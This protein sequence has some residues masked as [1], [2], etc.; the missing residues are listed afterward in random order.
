MSNEWT[1]SVVSEYPEE[2][3]V[4]RSMLSILQGNCAD[5][6]R[7]VEVDSVDSAD[8]VLMS[9]RGADGASSQLGN[10]QVLAQLLSPGEAPNGGGLALQR[11]VRAMPFLDFLNTASEQLRS[12]RN[13]QPQASGPY[14][15][16]PLVAVCHALADLRKTSTFRRP[17]GL[18]DKTGTQVA[19]VNANRGAVAVPYGLDETVERLSQDFAQAVPLT[20]RGWE[21]AIAVNQEQHL[22]KLCWKLGQELAR[23]EG[24]ACWLR[25]APSFRLLAWPDFGAIGTDRAGIRLSAHLSQRVLT[26]DALALATG[27]GQEEVVGFLNATSLCGLLVYSSGP[28]SRPRPLSARPPEQLS[29][30]ARLRSRLGL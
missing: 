26:P 25:N 22:D 14:R 6:W 19:A 21:D 24:L 3:A 4:V 10:G 13:V 12:L 11:P 30:I 17:L 2:V 29:V 8:L 16:T 1:V 28:V 15:S 18:V 7:Y 27:L 23:Q 20:A 5:R 9:S